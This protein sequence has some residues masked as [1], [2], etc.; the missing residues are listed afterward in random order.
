MKNKIIILISLFV[1]GLGA[2]INAQNLKAWQK[3]ADEAFE[4]KDYYSAYQF[5]NIAL[6]FDS[7]N[8]RNRFNLAESARLYGSY[9]KADSAYQVLFEKDVNIML[10]KSKV[11]GIENV[12]TFFP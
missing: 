9:H 12:S 7:T 11:V 1:A 6:E 3:A 10:P 8:I 4:R 2:T 5:Y